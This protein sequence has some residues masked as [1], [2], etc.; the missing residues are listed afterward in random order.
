MHLATSAI[1][2]TALPHGEH[3]AVVRFLTPDDG[4]QAG[5]VR[6][7]RS[8]RIRPTLQPGNVVALEL[9]ARVDTQLTAATVE[10]VTSRAGLAFDRL[11]AAATEWLA[12]VTAALLPEGQAHARLHAGLDA[13]LG[14]MSAGIPAADTAAG[15]ARYE[16][17]LLAELGFGLDL[18]QCAATGSTEELVYVSPRSSQA[19]SRGAGAP[20][21][22]KLLPLPAL[23]RED[24]AATG[25]LGVDD[26]LTT[27]G[28]FLERNLLIG[29]AAE[30]LTARARLVAIVRAAAE[31]AASAAA[32]TIVAPSP[33]G[34]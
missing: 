21:A 14:G 29:R 15:I 13:L 20:Y 25:W 5:Y 27:T 28:W 6:G 19:V 4:L 9:R 11:T 22:A 33:R 31:S 2:L 17:L 10:L 1:V 18:S 12:T 3:G 7:G 16:L 8:R 32:E 26:A 24:R 30:L 23:L 34:D